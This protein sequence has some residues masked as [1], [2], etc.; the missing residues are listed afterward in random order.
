MLL[1]RGK[2]I[3]VNKASYTEMKGVT[4]MMAIAKAVG[5]EGIAFGKTAEAGGNR[6]GR[7]ILLFIAAPWIGLIYIIAFPFIGFGMMVKYGMQAALK[8]VVS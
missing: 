1:H 4:E 6:V 7:N 5:M 8:K 3:E 2:G